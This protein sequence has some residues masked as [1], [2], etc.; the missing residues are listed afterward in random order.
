M[1]VCVCVS[2]DD[3]NLN[4]PNGYEWELWMNVTILCVS[5]VSVFENVFQ[6]AN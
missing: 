6:T 5:S 4:E 3:D 2:Y 1:C